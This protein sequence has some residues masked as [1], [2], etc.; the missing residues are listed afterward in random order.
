MSETSVT[1]FWETDEKSDS[2]GEFWASPRVTSPID[3]EMVLE[4]SIE[5]TNLVPGTTYSY[6]VMSRDKLGNL[7]VS[8]IYSFTTLGKAPEPEFAISDLSISPPEINIGESVTISVSVTNTG[9]LPGTY[10]LV[11]MID[12]R[13]CDSKEIVLAPGNEESLT[14]EMQGETAGEYFIDV[15]GLDSSFEVIEEPEPVP[16]V[17]TPS[18]APV[19]PEQPTTPPQATASSSSG[20][21]WR[22]LGPVIGVVVF[23]AVFLPIRMR[24]RRSQ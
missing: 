13:E 24:R 8:D 10:N 6:C 12:G 19:E 14:F 11:L 16:A 1:V 4:H 15:N 18:P 9:N 7:A 21:D 17:I 23:L 2:Q 3:E 5:F 22:I 20:I